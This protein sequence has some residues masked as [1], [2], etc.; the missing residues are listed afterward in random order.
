VGHV[1][2]GLRT[3][4]IK[5]PF[6]E[7][8]N[9]QMISKIADYNWCPSELSVDNLKKENAIG[10]I[11]YTGNTL[12][13]LI[14]ELYDKSFKFDR[15]TIIVTLHRRENKN[16]FI[17]II[18]DLNLIAAENK[19]FDFVIPVHP[20]PNIK[21]K[22]SL[23]NQNNILV[24][25]PVNYSKFINMI[26]ACH[27]II[28]DSG[29]IQEEAIFFNKK[30]LVCRNSTERPEGETIGLFKLVHDKIYENFDFLKDKSKLTY[31]NPYG[32]G[33]SCKKII[34]SII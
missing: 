18:N 22:V 34:R 13:D 26:G 33:D 5:S 8:F 14:I 21:E 6:P 27:G 25:E 32:N 3:Y 17:K 4:D 10:E 12:N 30:V 16:H 15:P 9:R 19:D 24:I 23:F 28:T 31:N 29:G 1:E 7:E 2:A 11:I 20:N